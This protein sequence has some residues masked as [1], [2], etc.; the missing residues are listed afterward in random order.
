VN[1]EFTA[2]GASRQNR[3]A[4]IKAEPLEANSPTSKDLAWGVVQQGTNP[5]GVNVRGV[6]TVDV[7]VDV[8]NRFAEN[9]ADT[10]NNFLLVGKLDVA[11]MTVGEKRCQGAIPQPHGTQ[12]GAPSN[13]HFIVVNKRLEPK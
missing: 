1:Q 10:A 5:N 6:A 8:N 13:F 2:T 9:V 4:T 7:L 3:F 12:G 11:Y